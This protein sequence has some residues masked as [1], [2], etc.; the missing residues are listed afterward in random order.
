MLPIQPP[1][2]ENP[3][4]SKAFRLSL[5][6]ASTVT[7][8]IACCVLL[9]GNRIE[10]QARGLD[11]RDGRGVTTFFILGF[12]DE[13]LGRNI[14]E[15]DDLI[16]RFYCDEGAKAIVFRR[17][18]ERL[19]REQGLAANIHQETFQGCLTMVRS[20]V[21]AGAV[22]ALYRKRQTY[23]IDERS[24]TDTAGRR[25]RLT[26]VWVDDRLFLGVERE[27][28]FA[29]VAGAYARHGAGDSMRFANARHK[30]AVIVTLLK[31]LGCSNVH[32]VSTQGRIPETNTIYF[33]PS[34]E[35]KKWL[36]RTW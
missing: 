36:D 33:Q 12:L 24:M 31:E 27:L 35:M 29:Y 19:A 4:V 9:T 18:L 17:Q 1:P 11:I 25:R 20:S 32:A 10:L 14:V 28:K 22:N 34:A 7:F 6:T 30:V 5:P 26:T 8:V 3:V 21:L 13:Y 2:R 16:E 15:G 23:S